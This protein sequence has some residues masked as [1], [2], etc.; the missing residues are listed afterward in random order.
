MQLNQSFKV[1]VISILHSPVKNDVLKTVHRCMY[2][3]TSLY[4]VVLGIKH[5]IGLAL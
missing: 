1:R 4:T 5:A 2:R 3:D